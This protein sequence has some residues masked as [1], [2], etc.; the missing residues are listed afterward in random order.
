[1]NPGEHFGNRRNWVPVPFNGLIETTL[2]QIELQS[3]IWPLNE[4]E[5]GTRT[6]LIVFEMLV[7]KQLARLPNESIKASTNPNPLLVYC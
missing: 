3:A 6:A 4:T 1:M 5:L 2:V 7:C